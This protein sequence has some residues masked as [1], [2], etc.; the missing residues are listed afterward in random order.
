VLNVNAFFYFYFY[1]YLGSSSFNRKESQA[2]QLCQYHGLTATRAP[3][4]ATKLVKARV[5]VACENEETNKNIGCKMMRSV[6]WYCNASVSI[7]NGEDDDLFVGTVS[8][9]IGCR[10]VINPPA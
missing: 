4:L 2:Q 6:R 3:K 9:H 10:W 1:F 5:G 8:P 7:N